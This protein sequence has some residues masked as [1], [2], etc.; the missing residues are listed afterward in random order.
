[1]ISRPGL[2]PGVPARDR[3]EGAGLPA[4]AAASVYVPR[5]PFTTGGDA[6]EPERTKN[7]HAR[8]NTIASAMMVTAKLGGRRFTAPRRPAGSHAP[9]GSPSGHGAYPARRAAGAQAPFF[10]LTG[11]RTDNGA[12]FKVH[13][14]RETVP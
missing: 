14:W 4:A 1:M 5:T 8:A 13:S 3:A 9:A 7:I 2:A 6:Q 10:A 11:A 12:R